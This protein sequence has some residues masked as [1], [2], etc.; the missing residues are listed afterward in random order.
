MAQG[1]AAGLPDVTSSVRQVGQPAL[2]QSQSLNLPRFPAAQTPGDTSKNLMWRLINNEVPKVKLPKVAAVLIG[3]NDIGA[4]YTNKSSDA[5][6]AVEAGTTVN[7]WV[8]PT[9][10]VP[11]PASLSVMS[12]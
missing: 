5:Q 12:A 6:L 1:F 3:M 7:R 10:A 4:I 9:A 11:S 2:S 8:P